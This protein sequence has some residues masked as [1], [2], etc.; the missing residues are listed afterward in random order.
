[1]CGK[2]E[3]MHDVRDAERAA[4]ALE[5]AAVRKVITG[6]KAFTH[7][8]RPPVRGGEPVWTGE[9]P[10]ELPVVKLDASAEEC[11]AGVPTREA[12][13][14]NYNLVSPLSCRVMWLVEGF[15]DARGCLDDATEIRDQMQ[16]RIDDLAAENSILLAARFGTAAEETQRG[17]E[18]AVE[19]GQ[20]GP[21][22]DIARFA[23]LIEAVHLART[24]LPHGSFYLPRQSEENVFQCQG[25]QL[26]I[27]A[28][29]EDCG[30][31]PAHKQDC[32]VAKIE[33]ALADVPE[34]VRDV[35]ARLQR[36]ADIER[37]T[38]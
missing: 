8:L 15:K 24:L 6:Y 29:L 25:C 32:P 34:A 22:F 18:A 10:H 4:I 26:W 21:S 38:A 27:H 12:I 2:D 33:R 5:H 19:R 9:L 16:S 13:P 3:F 14:R 35:L 31:C 36:L 28:R 23:S 20:R 17:I 11:G 7:D 30:S 37:R 1:M